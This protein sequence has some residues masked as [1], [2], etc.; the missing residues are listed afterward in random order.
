MNCAVTSRPCPP[1][2][3]EKDHPF[4]KT[5]SRNHPHLATARLTD[6]SEIGV[7]TACVVEASLMRQTLL[8][9]PARPFG[10][11]DERFKSHAWKACLG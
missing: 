4:L 11:V 6:T 1:R 9:Y 5:P 7:F 8:V 10:E 2:S 3:L